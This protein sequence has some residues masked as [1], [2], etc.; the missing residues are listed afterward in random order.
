MKKAAVSWI[1]LVVIL[2]AFAVITEAQRPKPITRIG[3]LAAGPAPVALVR[4]QA[5][6]EGLR[7]LGYVEG[8]D[9]VI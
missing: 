6:R 3:Y 5:F 4:V 8:R 9:I 1:L 2:L 7:A